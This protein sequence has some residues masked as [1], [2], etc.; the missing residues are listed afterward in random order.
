MSVGRSLKWISLSFALVTG[1]ADVEAADEVYVS[2]YYGGSIHVYP[3]DSNGDV[4]RTRTIRTGLSLPHDVAIDLLHRE[5]FVPNNR[6]AS[7]SPAI[8]AYDLD[9]G[10][11]GVSDAPKRTISGAATLLNRPAGLLVDSVHQE[12]YVANDVDVNAAVLVFPLSASGN[13]AP[14]RVLQGS[15]TTLSGPIGLALDLAHNELIVV[16]YKGADGGSITTFPRTA[17]GNT[18]PSRTIQG[19]STGFNR[20]QAVVLDLIH[21][22]LIVANSYFDNNASLGA[23]LAFSRTATGNVAPIRRVTGAN[24]GLCNP[25]GMTFDRMHD[26]LF[27]TNAAA[28]SACRPSVVIFA[29]SASG[30]A[31]PLRKIGPG[32]RCDLNNPEGVAVTTTVDCSDP[33]VASGTACNDND[34]CTQGEACRNSRCTGG[35]LLS[36]PGEIEGVTASQDRRTYGWSATANAIRYDVVRGSLG[37]L[38]VGP[39]GGDEVCFRNLE[40][41]TLTDDTVPANDEGFWYLARGAGACGAGTYGARHDGTPRITTTCP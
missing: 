10:M 1:L 27:V 20:P 33:L 22:E 38:G 31:A 8:N 30:N 14:R 34:P 7:Q 19:T 5:L 9:A 17:Q 18:A 21:N 12:L 3:R 35:T 41:A 26:E 16:G 2:N 36:V 23:L 4:T 13:V 32:D 37:S 11:L 40:S 24:T 29:R 28:N 25:I 6:P 15:L 39:G